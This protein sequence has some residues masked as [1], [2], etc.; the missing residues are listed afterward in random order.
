[1]FWHIKDSLEHTELRKKALKDSDGKIVFHRWGKTHSQSERKWKFKNH[2]LK[3][4]VF[5]LVSDSG[6]RHRTR[7]FM[8]TREWTQKKND[9]SVL[10]PKTA[11][12]LTLLR[13]DL[14]Y[15]NYFLLVLF[16]SSDDMM[17]IA[18]NIIK[19]ISLRTAITVIGKVFNSTHPSP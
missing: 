7:K 3:N 5:F 11:R 17:V 8:P 10:Q 9:I 12:D 6:K 16:A 2:S 13:T 4:C 15:I 1:M 18:W 14:F 19:F